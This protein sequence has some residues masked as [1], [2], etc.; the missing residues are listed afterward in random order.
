MCHIA[1]P[2]HMSGQRGGNSRRLEEEGIAE[3]SGTKQL[4]LDLDQLNSKQ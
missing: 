2:S 4:D 3:A 1:T